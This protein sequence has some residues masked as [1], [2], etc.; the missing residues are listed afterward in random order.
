MLTKKR[1]TPIA[2]MVLVSA[3]LYGCSADHKK[4]DFPVPE[5]VSLSSEVVDGKPSEV[6]MMKGLWESSLKSTTDD[7]LSE[8]KKDDFIKDNE[9]FISHL[10]EKISSKGAKLV[11]EGKSHLERLDASDVQAVVESADFCANGGDANE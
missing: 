7:E 9:C 3:S 2:L 4:N 1:V 5:G 6:D 8:D 11:A 10:H